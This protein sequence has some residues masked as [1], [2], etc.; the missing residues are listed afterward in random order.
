MDIDEEWDGE[1]VESMPFGGE[2]PDEEEEKSPLLRI[3]NRFF[4]LFIAVTVGIYA[5][6]MCR[7]MQEAWIYSA[8]FLG[9]ALICACVA[10]IIRSY[11]LK[12]SIT[13]LAIYYVI[14]AVASPISCWLGFQF[15]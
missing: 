15:Q 6:L 2:L 3:W 10:G 9:E 7:T 1:P 14:S 11:S 13:S 5:G 12:R 4:G 8:L